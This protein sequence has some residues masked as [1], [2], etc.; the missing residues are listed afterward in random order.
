MKMC[1]GVLKEIE[2]RSDDKY[3]SYRKV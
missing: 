3:V 1:Q 2:S